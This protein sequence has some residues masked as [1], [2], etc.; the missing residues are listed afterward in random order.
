MTQAQIQRMKDTETLVL[1]K[2]QTFWHYSIVPFLLIVPVLTTIDVFKFYVTHTYRAARP[3][4]EMISTGYIWI[5]PAIAFYFIQRRRLK[6]KII[7]VAVDRETF[8]KAVDKT[9]KELEWQFEE[10]TDD[11]IVAKSGFSWRSFG[12]QI[13]IIWSKDKILFNSIC[14]PDNR[15]S[16]TSAGMNRVN[17]K[18]FEKFINQ[19]AANNRFGV[20]AADETQHQ[21]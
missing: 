1:S 19:N 13:T 16:V 21:Q 17:R 15:P 8:E 12:E 4:D 7:N 11:T 5:L 3:I 20:M 2:G 9:A 10:V 18:L 14:D 6:F